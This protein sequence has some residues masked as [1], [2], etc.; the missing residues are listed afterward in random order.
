LANRTTIN[1]NLVA[2]SKT[3]PQ[4]NRVPKHKQSGLNN[5][6][7]KKG[8]AIELSQ[9]SIVSMWQKCANLATPL[10]S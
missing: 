6:T 4:R 8:K 9:L 10:Q 7:R 3:E 5:I 2:I 1:S